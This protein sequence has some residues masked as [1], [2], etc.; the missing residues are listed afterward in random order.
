MFSHGLL[1]DHE[2]FA[3]QVEH[4]RGR[5]RTVTWDE[6]SHGQTETSSE[7][8][9]FW[10]LAEDLA[11]LLDHLGVGMAV[12]AGMSQGGFIG[13]RFALRHPERVRGLLFMDSQA[14]PEP[15]EAVA[16]YGMMRQVWEEDGLND[17]LAEAIAAVALAPAWPGRGPW[18]EKWRR[19]DRSRLSQPWDCLI[20]REDLHPRLAEIQAPA[21]VVHGTEDVA[22]DIGQAERLCAGLP[23]C[24]RLVRVDGAGHGANLTH[25]EA[26]NRALDEFLAGLGP[27]P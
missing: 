3:P 14:G 4:L 24:R 23:G 7:P 2:M 27:T 10:D 5:H 18:I 12:L 17:Q 21:L 20:Q 1:M 19:L 16:Q 25:P 9:S 13:L 6:R 11:A 8:Y 26:V 22:I 15:P